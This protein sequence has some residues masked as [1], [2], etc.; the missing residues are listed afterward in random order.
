MSGSVS[1]PAGEPDAAPAGAAR[2]LGAVETAGR[3]ALLAFP[4][5][6][7]VY[8]SFNAGG[9]FPDDVAFAAILVLQALVL[10]TTLSREPAG[11]LGLLAWIPSAALALFTAWTVVSAAWSDAP[12][13]ALVEGNRALLYALVF[14]LFASVPRRP[15][16]VRWMVRGVA[17]AL[18]F[19]G[20]VAL[21]TR[22]FPDTFAV[23]LSI[24]PGRLS[25]PVTY[26]NALGV[27]AAV[28]ALLLLHLSADEEE[29]LAIRAAAAGGVP[30]LAVV[31]LFTFS[32][33]SI[34]AGFAGI[35]LYL[36]LTR[37]AGQI[38]ALVATGPATAVA[39]VSAYGAEQLASAEPTQAAAVEQGQDVA[40]VLA[41]VV[42]NAIVIRA[43]IGVAAPRI[44][45]LVERRASAAVAVRAI[46]GTVV[47]VAV[48]GLLAV[49]APAKG[50]DAV[51]EFFNGPAKPEQ[52]VD[53][54]SRLAGAESSGRVE[55]WEVALDGFSER[56]LHGHG[57]ASYEQLW[58][59]G[60]S[61]DERML[62][63]HSLFLE[64]LAELG[65]VGGVLLVV[66]LGGMLV[67]FV[68]RGRGDDR[69][70]HMALVSA[71]VL[72]CLHAATDWDWETPA[73]GIWLFAL[74]GLAA[75]R[76]AAP[77][78]HERDE[79]HQSKWPVAL[80]LAWIALAIGPL[81]V[82]LSEGRL[83]AAQ[84][85]LTQD[86]CRLAADE[87]LSSIEILSSRREPYEVLGFCRAMQGF[88]RQG[89]E[90]MVK[91]VERDPDNWEARYALALVRAQAGEDPRDDLERARRMS[92]LEPLVLAARERIAAAPR[93]DWPSIAAE[94]QRQ[95]IES[96]RLTVADQD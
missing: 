65:L 1:A 25:Y 60:R 63:A 35:L 12:G 62:D 26:W 40:L 17:A 64:V 86:D 21:A 37:G 81:V 3:A 93:G 73:T 42:V 52:S 22:L 50:R 34:V 5:F 69:M 85:A 61:T 13:R 68:V 31:V 51:D 4:A 77:P 20:V 54:R 57:A 79:P 78:G 38:A 58:N 70:L 6:L 39:L 43:A 56:P 44:T 23:D 59:E 76:A 66:A 30:I 10:R 36:A 55:Q 8:L 48:A 19:V 80:G 29:P 83:V 41:A 71:A 7:V 96:A 45:R 15:G 14:A 72:W 32:R 18:L 28:G 2:A 92:P 67:A 91:A 75:A 33:G 16:D 27:M 74:G 89:T 9:F 24:A 88:P 94:A 49:G 53:L 11:G 46:W 95:A 87:A 82:M 90:A 84:N 47:L